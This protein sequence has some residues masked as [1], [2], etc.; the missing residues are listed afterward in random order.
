MISVAL[1]AVGVGALACLVLSFGAE[2]TTAG[3]DVDGHSRTIDTTVKVMAADGARVA[4][5]TRSLPGDC[6]HVVVWTPATR[7]L[8]R[9]PVRAE[10]CTGADTIGS[11]ALAGTRAAWLWATT[12]GIGL[13]TGVITATLAHPTASMPVFEH[14]GADRGT[15]AGT[16]TRRPVGHGRL[17]AFTVEHGCDADAERKEGPGAPDQCPPGLGSGDIDTASLYRLGGPGPCFGDGVSRSACTPIARADGRLRVL[18]V[19]AGRIAAGTAKGITLFT[20]AGAPVKDFAV[21]AQATALSGNRLAVR[22]EN[23]VEVYETDSGRLATRFPAQSSLRLQ[24]LE[25]DI[26]VT[27]NHA[28]ITLRKLSDGRSVRVRT[29]GVAL[30]QLEPTGLFTAGAGRLTFTPMHEVRRRLR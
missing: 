5:I 24:D 3:S 12:T 8:R 11:V 27:A 30:A 15:G 4:F 25:G 14:S 26:L 21:R 16:F 1:L 7:S 18:A 17:L 22:T 10:P 13:E 28:T 19:D 23:A 29:G 9:F 20:E 2:A 6:E